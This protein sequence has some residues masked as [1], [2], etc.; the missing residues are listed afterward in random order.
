MER[1]AIIGRL[2]SAL[3]PLPYAYALWL[4]GA[5]ATGM[6]DEYSDLD[7]WLDFEDEYEAQIIQDVESALES[8]SSIDY[9]YV[10]KHGHSKIRQRIYHLSGTSEYL[11]IDFCWQLHSR[12]DGV[13][14]KD[15]AIEAAKV[16]FDKAYVV[17]YKDYNPAD[18]AEDN[19]V[20]LAESKY[21]MSQHCRVNKYVRRGQY[22]EAFGYYNRYVVEPLINALRLVYTPD[23]ADYGIVHISHHIPGDMLERLEYFLRIAS[24]EDIEKK[25]GEAKLWFEELI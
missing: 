2:K 25:T 6:I 17:R 24:L 12:E 3:E 13:L 7:F 20:R 8:L 22:A 15:D 16:I 9:K 5:D 18:V 14:I 4:E 1:D 19:A 21:R 10:M 23:H 11:M